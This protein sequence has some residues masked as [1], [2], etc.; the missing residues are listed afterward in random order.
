[1]SDK[2]KILIVDD[3]P[4]NPMIMEAILNKDYE[5]ITLSSGYDCLDKVSQIKPDVIYLDVL[6][7][8]MDGFEVCKRLRETNVSENIPIIF[9][10]GL[11]DPKEKVK[12]YDV[13]GD[14]F[15]HKPVNA[16]ELLTKTQI[17]VKSKKESQQL[18]NDMEEAWK[19]AMTA[20]S[21]AGEL[22]T[23]INFFQNSFRCHS[24]REVIQNILKASIDLDLD[25]SVQ[26]RTGSM[27]ITTDRNGR[28]KPLEEDIFNRTKSQGRIVDFGKRI[29]VNFDSLSLLIKNMPVSDTEKCGRIKDYL[30]IIAEG[31]ESLVNG[32][33]YKIAFEEKRKSLQKMAKIT[34]EA[35]QQL[36]AKFQEQQ[37]KSTE[38]VTELIKDLEMNF[39]K[40]GLEEDQEEKVLEL[41]NSSL[42]TA[43][44]FNSDRGNIDKILAAVMSKL[45]KILDDE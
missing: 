15:I 34:D 18:K 8:E 32:I 20:M 33:S 41:V 10:S 19:T 39:L 2:P 37:S 45:S 13:G 14:D 26:I 31:A 16:E 6:M 25:C 44:Q 4:V 30:P 35:M 21:G 5:V 22:G 11:N 9:V 17:T 28:H 40:M 12:G 29:V 36:D 3:E 43:L 27:V 42:E 23:I 1:M 38:L 7:P 24:Y